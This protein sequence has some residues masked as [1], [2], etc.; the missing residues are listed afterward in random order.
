M[1]KDQNG[2]VKAR[3]QDAAGSLVDRIFLLPARL[4]GPFMPGRASNLQEYE[5][6]LDFYINGGYVDNPASFF[7]FPS[8]TPPFSIIGRKPYNGG[9]CRVI[10]YISGYEA[11]NPLI[12]EA[13]Q[14]HAAN[15]NGYLVM[16]THGDHPRKTVLCLH[17]YMLGEP[18]QAERMF[19]VKKL[20]SAGLDV[21]LFIAPFHWK[22]RTGSIAGR[23]F[24]LQPGNVVMTC[25]CV[26]QCMHDLYGAFRILFE[27]GIPEAGMIGASLGGYNTA[28]FACLSDIAAFGAMMVP[29]VNFSQPLG[30]GTVKHPFPVSDRLR[31]KIQQV[32]ELHSPLNLDPKIEPEK[33]LV[34][35]SRGDMLCPF[36]NVNALCDRWGIKNRHFLAGGHWLI[37]DSGRRGRVWYAFLRRRGFL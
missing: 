18:E 35:A 19:K 26:G 32:W 3:L 27:L 11:K 1:K 14:A 21:A 7:T 8:T 36:E 12:C 6:Q 4:S 5:Q 25:E 17:G 28:L 34:V 2:T 31:K 9:E 10:R 33:L 20:Y 22:R 30:P 23:G 29:A 16:W 15:R 13:Y 24:F 37:F